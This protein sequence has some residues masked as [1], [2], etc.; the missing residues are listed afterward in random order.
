MRPTFIRLLWGGFA[1]TV[2]M[3]LMMIFVAPM[4]GV[5]MDIAASLAT[6]LNGP[7]AIGMLVHLMMGVLIFSVVYGYLLQRRLPGSAPVRGMIWGAVL[8]LMLEA[9]VMPM[10]GNGFFGADGPGGKG[11]MAALLAHLAYG[12]LL[13][14]IAAPKPSVS[15]E[16]I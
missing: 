10:L 16:A 13:G 6:M 7:W 1:G 14:W 9:F 8:W 11:A 3:T 5:H 12:A 15:L 4:M 2:A